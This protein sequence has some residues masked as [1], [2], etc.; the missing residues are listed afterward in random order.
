MDGLLKHGMET[1]L[2]KGIAVEI[3]CENAGTCTTD[4]L[5]FKGFLHR[6]Y[7]TITQLAPYTAETIRP[8]L[9][10]S[11]QAA[12]KQCT[13]GALGRQCGFKW[14]SGVYDGKT[15]AGQEMAALSAVMSLLIPAAKPPLTEKDGGTSKGNPNAG[16]AGDNA[17]KKTK[18]ITTADKAGAGILTFLVLGS[19]CGIFGWMS[20]GA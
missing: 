9:Q 14:A 13:G 3:S 2:P 4:M 12:I 6:W 5:T 19:A 15:G 8:V 17:Q 10:T 7:S 20:V 16:G 18:P 1:F 11:A